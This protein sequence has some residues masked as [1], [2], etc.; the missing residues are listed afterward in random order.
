MESS[1]PSHF[2]HAANYPV[3]TFHQV[4]LNLILLR[5][6]YVQVH[7]GTAP[8]PLRLYRVDPLLATRG[9][10]FVFA[11][12]EASCATF[13]VPIHSNTNNEARGFP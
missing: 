11:P 12:K 4:S 9:T 10:G 7:L 1:P 6:H 5:A 2:A 13:T 3:T 8:P